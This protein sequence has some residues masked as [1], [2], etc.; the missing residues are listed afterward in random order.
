[1]KHSLLAVVVAGLVLAAPA[2]AGAQRAKQV[3]LLQSVDRG[4]LPLDYFSGKFRVDLE[5]QL[6]GH[7]NVVELVVVPPGLV[8]SPERA[9]ITYLMSAFAD[10]PRP[11]LIV[12]AGGP[13]AAF[14]RRHRGELFPGTPVLFASVD[15]RFLQDAPLADNESAVTVFNSFAG[16][17]DEILQLFPRTSRV[18]VVLGSGEIARFWRPVLEREFA[19]FR[20]RLTF[21]W[22]D[23]QSYREAL[24]HAAS[25]PR[26]SAILYL[27]FGSDIDG[28]SYAD[29]RA[30]ADLHAVSPVPIF[31]GQT[32]YLGHGIVGGTLVSS[33]DLGLRAAAVAARILHGESPTKTRTVSQAAGPPVFDGREL[34]RWN[35]D[36]SRLPPDSEVLFEDANIWDRYSVQILATLVVVLAQGFLIVGL[37]VQ[38]TR[39]QRAEQQVQ[40]GYERIRE[41]GSRLLKAQDTERSR[42]AR[43][44]HDDISQQMA[45]LA[46]DVA[47]LGQAGAEDTSRL[48]GAALAR[49]EQINQSVHELSHRLHPAK[50]RLLGLTAA[51]QG[52]CTELE[53]SGLS[54]TFIHD[55]IQP[56]LPDLTVPLFRVVQEA[57]HNTLKYSGARHATVLLGAHDGGLTLVV[58]DD[59]S[60]FDV[61][62]AWNTG[63]GL[64]SMRERID[65]IGGALDIRSWPGGGTRVS[66]TVPSD[67]L[68]PSAVSEAAS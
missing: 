67:R 13:A 34:R 33:E 10:G 37:L 43:E 19:R 2:P 56:L 58:T 24:R 50:L 3:L 1:M 21:E 16:D 35:V 59:G 42:I 65:A 30:L 9:V 39:R 8:A 14:V 17:V 68:R 11:D 6:G 12:T 31:G 63:L 27:T 25:L 41:L 46:A 20:N 57:L 38:K 22:S 29:S 40:A 18:F 28:G 51:L 64:A 45:T 36:K 15:E 5:A 60:G 52:L 47:R 44:L 23:N 4:N 61:D 55:A 54:I 53:Q 7:V 48:A 66:I 62:A 49:V 32:A 26:D